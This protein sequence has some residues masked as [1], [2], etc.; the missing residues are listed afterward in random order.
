MHPGSDAEAAIWKAASAR[1]FPVVDELCPVLT[2]RTECRPLAEVNTSSASAVIVFAPMPA[3]RLAV[4]D[5]MAKMQEDPPRYCVVTP[6]NCANYTPW[7]V[8]ILLVG[9]HRFAE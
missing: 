5:L 2:I 8:D 7:G 1:L 9:D 4:P 6:G 3:F